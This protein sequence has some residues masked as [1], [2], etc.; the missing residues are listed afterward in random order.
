MSWEGRADFVLSLGCNRPKAPKAPQV[1]QGRRVVAAKPANDGAAVRLEMWDAQLAVVREIGNLADIAV[2]PL[3]DDV[4]RF[5]MTFYVDQVAGL[6]AVY[7]PRGRQLEKIQVADDKGVSRAFAMLENHGKQVS[8]DRFDVYSW[9]GHLPSST[10]YPESYVLNSKEEVLH[11]VISSFNAEK[12]MLTLT[13]KDGEESELS[14]GELRR[15]VI[16]KGDQEQN[17]DSEGDNSE[18]DSSSEAEGD[19]VAADDVENDDADPSRLIEIEFA[20]SSRLIGYLSASA[21]DA[22]QFNADGVEGQLQCPAE[23]VVAIIGS[24]SR[25]AG[26]QLPGTVGALVNETTNLKGCL[27]DNPTPDGDAVLVW[28]PWASAQPCPLSGDATGS[29]TYSKPRTAAG[30][31]G[32]NP[33]QAAPRPPAQPAL[34]GLLG[35]L[36]GGPANANARPAAKAGPKG[37]I[38]EIVFSNWRYR[39]WYRPSNRRTWC[40]V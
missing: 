13:G 37:K 29:I 11:G 25:F 16:S 3:D 34:G 38:Y 35:G 31:V 21:N 10:E 1:Q 22:F 18:G 8:L 4:S 20:D 2:L 27:T 36:F 32:M 30:A 5:D 24:E 17:Q 23:N 39:R 6:V 7:S 28:Q 19:E 14:I 12:G 33:P 15:L 9:D 26:D 40:P